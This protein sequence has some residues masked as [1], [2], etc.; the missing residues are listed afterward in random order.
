[1]AFATL[2]TGWADPFRELERMREEMDRVFGSLRLGRAA[3]YPPMNL[4]AGE[5]GIVVT[6]RVPGVSPENI[7]ITVHQNTLTLRGRRAPDAEGEDVA[8]HR[9]ERSYGS[10]ARTVS[11]PFRVDPDRVAARF[12]NGVLTIE[13]PRPEADKPKRI[14][15]TRG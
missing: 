2:G 15:V 7:D 5:S 13:L 10:F 14:Q 12:E 8:Y 1:M 4:W 9:Q 3:E 6:A 11:L